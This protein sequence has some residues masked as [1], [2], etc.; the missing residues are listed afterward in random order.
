MDK[1]ILEKLFERIKD[2]KQNPK[3]GS[4]VNKLLDDIDLN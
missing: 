2:R 4:Y 1:N 3:Q